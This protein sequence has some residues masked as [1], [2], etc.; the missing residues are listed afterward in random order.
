MRAAGDHARS[1]RSDER[2][3]LPRCSSPP[4]D[5]CPRVFRKMAALG[6]QV[7]ASDCHR[8]ISGSEFY[9]PR[10]APFFNRSFEAAYGNPYRAPPLH[11]RRR[12]KHESLDDLQASTYF[13]PTTVSAS[14]GGGK[15]SAGHGGTRAARP[16]DSLSFNVEDERLNFHRNGES[17]FRSP[18]RAAEAAAPSPHPGGLKAGESARRLRVRRTDGPSFREAS[19]SVG[20]LAEG[21]VKK[22]PAGTAR[23][24]FKASDQDSELIADDISDIFRFL[25]EMS[26]CDSLGAA[27]SSR[28]DS[29][30]SL[31]SDSGDSLPERATVRL[32]R[33]QPDRLLRSLDSA[34]G[35]LKVSVGELVARMGD[36][37]KKLESLS[38]VRGEISQVLRKLNKLDQKI[39]EPDAADGG[40][41]HRDAPES[42]PPEA[43]RG[44]AASPHAFRCRTLPAADGPRVEAPKKTGF[45]RRSSRSLDDDAG[46][47]SPP[48]GNWRTRS[49][50]CRRD[51]GNT[52]DGMC[53]ANQASARARQYG[54]PPT[55]RPPKAAAASYVPDR[56]SRPPP[57][58]D[59][60]PLYSNVRMAAPSRKAERYKPKAGDDAIDVQA[61]CV[62]ASNKLAFWLEDVYTPGYDSLLKRREADF[63]RA[64]ACKMA[65]LI[66]ATFS[67]IL[68]IVVPICTMKT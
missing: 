30:P 17:R 52:G 4:G 65:A 35:E 49:Y 56:R 13:G 48:P 64:K 66:A 27:P 19:A 15:A 16:A 6:P 1:E 3:R 54:F 55:P 34:D 11:E 18:R 60:S 14:V 28:Y 23:A 12:V 62:P 41:R 2:R 5:P 8:G 67:V 36:I 45:T 50:L 40:A 39:R 43:S 24:A 31:G 33:S 7:V 68:V 21:G 20:T 59:G 47:A 51:D 63:R 25:D 10:P 58:A 22:G 57:H 32:A 9:R 29:G 37:E 53:C 42:S 38:G 26:V 61:E 46:A 44:A